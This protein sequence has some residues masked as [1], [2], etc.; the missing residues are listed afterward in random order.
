MHLS[1]SAKSFLTCGFVLLAVGGCRWW[2]GS[3]SVNNSDAP[4]PSRI[5]FSTAEPE[6]FQCEVVQ[7]DGENEQ[8][9]FYARKNGNWR[10]DLDTKET[11]LH[12]DKYYRLN[13]EKKIYAEAP[14]GDPSATGP[15]FVSDMTWSA[16]KQNKN[17]KFE[18]MGSDGSLA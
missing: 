12:T 2:Q 7:S 1:N 10:L 11:I 18:P 5:P 15:E 14:L 4:A 3:G 8:K 17:A 13:N 9:T 6:T 16:L